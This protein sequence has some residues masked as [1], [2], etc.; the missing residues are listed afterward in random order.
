MGCTKRVT[1]RQGETSTLFVIAKDKSGEFIDIELEDV[2]FR[3]V[4]KGC[5]SPVIDLPVITTV[6]DVGMYHGQVRLSAA[7]SRLR[8]GLYEYEWRLFESDGSVQTL[9]AGVLE[10]LK[11]LFI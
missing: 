3:M 8:A 1:M 2:R 6:A 10:V 4:P 9:E 5:G 11:S 7:D